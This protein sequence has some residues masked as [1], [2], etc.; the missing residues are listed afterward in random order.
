MIA[1]R[2][3]PAPQNQSFFRPGAFLLMSVIATAA[4]AEP[5]RDAIDVR[6]E[7]DASVV[8]VTRVAGIGGAEITLPANGPGR[9]VVRFVGFPELESIKAGSAQGALECT[10][11]RPER[12]APV[13]ECR[14]DGAVVDLLH[15][16]AD[17]FELLIPGSLL[18]AP[19]DTVALR[20]VD[21]WR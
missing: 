11:L 16:T 2:Y 14:L 3:P 6:V 12:S 19:G 15:R 1:S 4:I 9:V 8:T 21:Q 17:G 5:P 7:G 10:L 20:W 13:R 18:M